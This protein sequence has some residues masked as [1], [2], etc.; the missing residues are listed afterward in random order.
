MTDL[1][2]AVARW[3][4]CLWDWLSESM[5]VE[6]LDEDDLWWKANAP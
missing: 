4:R 3:W 6:D 5:P 2:H 1:I